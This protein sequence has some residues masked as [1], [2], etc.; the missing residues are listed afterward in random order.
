MRKLFAI[1]STILA[2]APAAGAHPGH[3]VQDRGQG[4][5]HHLTEPVHLLAGLAIVVCVVVLTRLARGRRR[6]RR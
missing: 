3:G 1:V 4:L 5:V 6:I 2:L